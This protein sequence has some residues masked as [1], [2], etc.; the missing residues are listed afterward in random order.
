MNDLI[1]LPEPQLLFKYGE[2][3]DDPRDGLT[4][5]GPLESKPP[6]GISY[7]VVGTDAGINRFYR[8]VEKV[9]QPLYHELPSKR[10]L[11]IPFP[12]FEAAF[13]IPFPAKTVVEKK[14]DSEMLKKILRERDNYQ[15]VHKTVSLYAEQILDFY[16]KADESINLWFVLSPES[17]FKTCRPKSTASETKSRIS[18]SLIRKRKETSFQRHAGQFTI[19]EDQAKDYEAYQFDSDFRRQLKARLIMEKIAHPVQIIRETTIAPGDFLDKFGN[20]IRELEPESQVAWN[21]LSTVFY[22][23]GGKPW[24]LK[25][26]RDGVCYLGMVYKRLENA[27]DSR[28]AC[29][30]AQMFLDSGDGVVFKGAVG[31]WKS[32]LYED[33]HLSEEAA[34]EIIQKALV[35][36]EQMCGK[37]KKPKEIFIHGKTY[38]NDKEWAGFT[39]PCDSSIKVVGVR[40]RK[41]NLRLYRPGNWPILRGAAYIENDRKGFLWSAGFIPRLQSVPFQGIPYP[42][43]IEICKGEADINVVHQ[44]VLALT[45]LNYNGCHFADGDPITLNFADKIGDIITAAPIKKDDAPLPFKFYI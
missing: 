45:K 41:G 3:L 34:R 43:S 37:D 8:W 15:R 44:D 14:V 5:F 19:F 38:L 28:S 17:V 35:A 6:F 26:I 36:Y 39:S 42:L 20:E 29:C 11:W 33:Y 12:G 10:D 24:K 16:K 13:G 30:A 40:I 31:P 22:K 7:G 25:G 2:A 27:P 21:L 32:N 4:L 18:H 23:A 9:Q 1:Y